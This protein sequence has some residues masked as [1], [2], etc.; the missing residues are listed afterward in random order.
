MRTVAVAVAATLLAA[1]PIAVAQTLRLPKGSTSADVVLLVPQY[2][3]W[4][5]IGWDVTV[6]RQ[7]DLELQTA[8]HVRAD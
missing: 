7:P 1:A 5:Q 3:D 6:D 4:Q 8:W 2:Q